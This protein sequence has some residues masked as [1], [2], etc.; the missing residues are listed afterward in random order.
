MGAKNRVGRVLSY[1]G[2]PGYTAWRNWFLGINSWAPQ[3]F[4][5]SGC[6]VGAG[7]MQSL[8]PVGGGGHNCNSNG[9]EDRSDI[10]WVGRRHKF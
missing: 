5:N 1:T 4:K 2:S 9:S 8:V 3:K 6:I 7:R 10:R